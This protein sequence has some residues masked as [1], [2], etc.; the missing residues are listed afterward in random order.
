VIRLSKAW[1]SR[2]RVTLSGW[3]DRIVTSRAS[4]RS[5]V[6]GEFAGG[7]LLQKAG[8]AA[9]P[10]PFSLGADDVLLDLVHWT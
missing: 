6:D 8:D 10:E 1:I 4:A 7:H 9:L 5:A 2:F 3:G